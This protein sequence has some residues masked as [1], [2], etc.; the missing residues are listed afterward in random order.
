MQAE[1]FVDI[2]F[3]LFLKDLALKLKHLFY[4]HLF[5]LSFAEDYDDALEDEDY[6]LIE[7]NLG[8]KVQRVSILSTF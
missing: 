7:E 1:N 5:I 4:K 2:F 8:V 3:F 6:D